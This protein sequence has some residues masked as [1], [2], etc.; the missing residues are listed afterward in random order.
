M[1]VYCLGGEQ[2]LCAEKQVL[3][4]PGING[5]DVDDSVIEVA[6]SVVESAF[7]KTGKY[8][9]LAFKDM[10]EILA[11]QALSLSGMFDAETAAQIGRLVSARLIVHGEIV[12]FDDSFLLSL[13]IIDV[14]TG[15]TERAEIQKIPGMDEM[16]R[17][18]HELVYRM[19]DMVYHPDVEADR[20]V[21]ALTLS[22]LRENMVEIVPADTPD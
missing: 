11:A 17:K 16:E 8:R 2:P 21:A 22:D 14:E 18:I 19:V 20:N 13:R 15:N 4:V 6:R 7:L 9:V 5:V 1:L 10:E 3:G 12:G